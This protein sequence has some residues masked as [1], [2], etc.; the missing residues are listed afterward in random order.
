MTV[1]VD[2][3]N[4]IFAASTFMPGVNIRAIE[5]SRA[6]LLNLLAKYK[7]LRDDRVVV[8][9]DGG[10]EA[11]HLPRRSFVLGMEVVFSESKS[12]ADSEIKNAVSCHDTPRN[13][14]VVT[15]DAEI[16]RIVERCGAQVTGSKEFLDELRE[17]MAENEVP[18][19]EPVEKYGGGSPDEDV[20]YWRK[21]FGEDPGKG[22]K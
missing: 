12:D 19:D 9:F 16:R 2:G 6:K 1:F 18:E 15:S 13:I 7:A 14:R 20:N 3:Y 10:A 5:A 17:L 11:A 21:V 22:K 8:F 4:L